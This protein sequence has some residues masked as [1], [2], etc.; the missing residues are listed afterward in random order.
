MPV[1]PTDQCD[2]GSCPA[3]V[4]VSIQ[5]PAGPLGFCTH[6]YDTN[7]AALVLAGCDRT[8]H[9]GNL[10]TPGGQ[11][12]IMSKTPEP[13]IYQQEYERQ[14]AAGGSTNTYYVTNGVITS[15]SI[16]QTS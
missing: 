5:T 14:E 16:A 2:Q 10:K 6:H 8:K 4:Q 3:F 1:Q 15:A 11:E 13:D 9:I 12:P 7:F